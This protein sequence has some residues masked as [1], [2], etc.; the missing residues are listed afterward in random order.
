MTV[1]DGPRTGGNS[2]R[3]RVVGE[4]RKG[5]PTGE[6]SGQTEADAEVDELMAERAHRG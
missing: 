4:G 5:E 1:G 3:H 6:G 2:L